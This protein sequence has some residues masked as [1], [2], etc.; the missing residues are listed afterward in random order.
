[1]VNLVPWKRKKNQPTSRS[2]LV[3]SFDRFFDEP[4]LSAFY[5]FN[6]D[7]WWPRVDVSE[8]KNT[9]TVEAEIPGMDKNDIELSIE[10]GRYLHIKGQKSREK[11]ENAEDYYRV[12]R[13]YGYFNRTLELPAA[14]DESEVNAKYRRGVLKI[15]LK[16]LKNSG[17]QPIKIK[18][19]T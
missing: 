16:K 18:N 10:E 17:A 9:I 14:V 4:F 2:N 7:E 6:R 1:M 19:S 15:K 5:P 8:G 13:A 12:E 11:K 3:N